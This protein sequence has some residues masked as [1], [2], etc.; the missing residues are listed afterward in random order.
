[1]HLF[2]HAEGRKNGATLSGG[3]FIGRLATYF[4]LVSDEG[5]RAPGPER[6]QANAAGAPAAAEG[7]PTADEGAQAVSAPVQAPQPLPPAP[8][9]RTIS[10]TEQTRVS[11]WMISCMTQL[12]DA[13]G[14]TY[15][16]FDNTI[17]GSS[18]L[19]YQ[20]R[21]RPRTSDASTSAAPRTDD[22]PDP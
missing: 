3:H 9:P 13:S 10:F 19:P 20:R 6:Q 8:Q 1:Q 7:A 4:G 21:V 22:Q 2:W 15:Q 18:R 12:M 16:A 14:R 5:L 11:T 17:V